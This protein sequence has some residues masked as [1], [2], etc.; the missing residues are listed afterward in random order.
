[1]GGAGAAARNLAKRGGMPGTCLWKHLAHVGIQKVPV[2]LDDVAL[3]AVDKVV[4]NVPS[5]APN[6]AVRTLSNDYL[7]K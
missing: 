6:D 7:K 4:G 3:G 2:E 1:M 5:R